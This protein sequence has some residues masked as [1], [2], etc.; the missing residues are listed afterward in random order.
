MVTTTVARPATTTKA[1]RGTPEMPPLSVR[2]LIHTLAALIAATLISLGARGFLAALPGARHSETIHLA[3]QGKTVPVDYLR[4]A[5]ADLRV[6]L[7]REPTRARH[8]DIATLEFALARALA[9]RAPSDRDAAR[10]ARRRAIDALRA[11]LLRAPIEPAMWTQLGWYLS[12]DDQPDAALHALR[13]ATLL[14][15]YAPEHHW[16]RMELWLRLHPF[17]RGDDI[18]VLRRQFAILFNEDA[19]RLARLADGYALTA[20]VRAHLEVTAGIDASELARH[21]PRRSANGAP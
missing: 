19:A 8:R 2:A 15:A 9:D 14:A 16:W 10:A 7:E 21:F 3:E 4:D 5:L 12:F 6:G 1:E 18:P 13:R 11:G 17:L 20:T